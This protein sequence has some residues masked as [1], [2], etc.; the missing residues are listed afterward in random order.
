MRSFLVLFLALLI[1]VAIVSPSVIALFEVG[2]DTAVLMDLNEEEQQQEEK[3]EI[4]EPLV[5]PSSPFFLIA[6]NY[7]ASANFTTI[8]SESYAANSIAVFLPPP[9]FVN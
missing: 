3:K 5:Y 4:D 6:S 1:T 8:L 7:K 2:N 9:K